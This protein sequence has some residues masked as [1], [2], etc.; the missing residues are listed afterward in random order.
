[1]PEREAEKELARLKAMERDLEAGDL[2]SLPDPERRV[3]RWYYASSVSAQE[4]SGVL[5][6]EGLGW[7]ENGSRYTVAIA[8]APTR[9]QHVTD[10][11]SRTL[12][13]AESGDYTT[14]GGGTWV[15]PR[16]SWPYA[17]DCGRFTGSGLG[18]MGGPIERSLKPRSR[19]GGG[20]VQTLAGD[21]SVR[22]IDDAIE[23]HL[24]ALLWP[25]LHEIFLERLAGTGVLAFEMGNLRRGQAA[26]HVGERRQ[27]SVERSV[28]A[29]V[30]LAEP[31]AS[32]FARGRSHDLLT[33]LRKQ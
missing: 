21:A 3:D 4:F 10:G 11:L 31:A 12:M 25:G 5:V 15:A 28:E 8:T 16:Y 32:L 18:S 13:I 27:R 1:M 17:S 19:I 33:R 20:V 2:A 26:H 9:A 30:D 22:S 14:D 29:L 6:P 7:I 23:L 24:L